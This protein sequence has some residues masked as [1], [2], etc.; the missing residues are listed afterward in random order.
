MA[1]LNKAVALFDRDEN[2]NVL[3]QE[4]DLVLDMEDKDE[5]SLA[6]MKV[7]ITP[8]LRGELKRLLSTAIPKDDKDMDADIIVEHCKNPAFTK[9]DVKFMKNYVASAIVNTILFHS[10][11]NVGNKTKK[12]AMDEAEDEFGK[13]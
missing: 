2:N 9:E 13:N 4:V 1:I 10:G 7:A 11:I 6:G 12:K 8:L 3:P 5:K